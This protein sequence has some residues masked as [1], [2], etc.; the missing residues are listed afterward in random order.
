MLR[1]SSAE[2]IL[3][4][5]GRDDMRPA[6]A[7]AFLLLAFAA[8]AASAAGHRSEPAG[9]SRCGGPL[10]R[11]KTLSDGERG[12]VTLA[13]KTTTIQSIGARPYP[14]PT[15]RRRRTQFQRQV[16]EVVA[17]VTSFRLDTEGVRLILYDAGSYMNAVIPIPACLSRR[18]LAREELLSVWNRFQEGCDH[19]NRQWQ[20]LGAIVYV[21]GVG[22]WS[23]RSKLRRGAARNGAELHPVTGFRV[24]AGC[25]R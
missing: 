12:T 9:A 21:S 8:A 22:F 16:W 24:V 1:K 15:P 17:Q 23:Q 14:R 7:I 10:W 4:K 3:R 18:T 11:L 6:A 25:R 2:V 19:A 20:S 13:A 5:S